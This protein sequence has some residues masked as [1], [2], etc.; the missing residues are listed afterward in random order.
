M[1]NREFGVRCGRA[2]GPTRCA[3]V[4]GPSGPTL[5]TQFA[6]GRNQ[7]IVPTPPAR[8]TSRP[9]PAPDAGTSTSAPHRD[10]ARR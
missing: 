1:T 4:A 2:P 7:S 5:S 6:A 9:A 10:S 8:L 3:T